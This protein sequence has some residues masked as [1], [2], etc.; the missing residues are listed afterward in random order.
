MTPKCP[1]CGRD[2]DECSCSN[3]IESL[4]MNIAELKAEIERLNKSAVILRA[5]IKCQQHWQEERDELKRQNAELIAGAVTEDMLLSYQTGY[6][7]G[8]RDAAQEGWKL[9]PIEPTNV[10]LGAGITAMASSLSAKCISCW[11][12]MLAAAPSPEGEVK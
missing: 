5:T 7:A 1:D 6:E 9:V 2:Q 3:E 11:D 12:A 8:K 4:R 10:M